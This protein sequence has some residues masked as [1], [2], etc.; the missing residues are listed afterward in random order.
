MGYSWLLLLILGFPPSPSRCV[1]R[2]FLPLS[3]TWSSWLFC[4]HRRFW[5]SLYRESAKCFFQIIGQYWGPLQTGPACMLRSRLLTHPALV[6]RLGSFRLLRLILKV[7]KLG[8]WLIRNFGSFVNFSS[9]LCTSATPR[10]P[11]LPEGPGLRF[12]V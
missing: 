4:Q 5:T 2:E 7:E 10:S 8:L 9:E 1:Y 3:A 12:R 11:I 6:S